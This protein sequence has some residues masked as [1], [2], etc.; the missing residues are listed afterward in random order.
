MNKYI[1]GNMFQKSLIQQ[2]LEYNSTLESF[3]KALTDICESYVVKGNVFGIYMG[4]PVEIHNGYFVVEAEVNSIQEAIKEMDSL[5][6]CV[7]INEDKFQV[8][9]VHNHFN[10]ICE[11]ENTIIDIENQCELDR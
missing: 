5:T 10:T 11:S 8:G 7:R 3:K 2:T 6:K 9:T 1:N 4:T